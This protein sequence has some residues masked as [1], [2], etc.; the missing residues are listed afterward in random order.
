MMKKLMLALACGAGLSGCLFANYDVPLSFR[1][2]TRYDVGSVPPL[3]DSKGE[4]CAFQ[5]LGLLAFGN[6]G[7]DAAYQN[8]LTKSG[9]T[10]LFDVRTDTR[11]FN[12]LGIYS[13][14]CTNVTGKVAKK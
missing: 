4:A 11:L 3:G 7:F 10:E 6:G 12:V 9:A 5:I 14:S 8:A 1:T 13:E 2:E